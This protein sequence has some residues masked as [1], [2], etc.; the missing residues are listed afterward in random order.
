MEGASNSSSSSSSSHENTVKTYRN[1]DIELIETEGIPFNIQQ[2]VNLPQTEFEELLETPV[3]SDEQKTTCKNIR[4]RGR[5]KV[6]AQQSRQRK[7]DQHADL[8]TKVRH[9]KNKFNELEC[10]ENKLV[11]EKHE[12]S[13]ELN[14]LIDDYLRKNQ[15]DPE[16]YAVVKIGNLIIIEPKMFGREPVGSL[17]PEILLSLE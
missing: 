7:A 11:Q 15:A 12:K 13:A 5:N 10:T 2:I 16:H 3:L 4:R 1:K 6:S 14:K 17:R 8:E 9:A